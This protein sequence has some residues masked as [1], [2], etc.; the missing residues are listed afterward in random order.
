MRALAEKAREASRKLAGVQPGV[1]NAALLAMA[2]QLTGR[3]TEMIEANALDLTA[4]QQRGLSPAMID[5]LRL[6][7]K[8]IQAMAHGIKEVAALPD[9]VG[10]VYDMATRPNGLK[11]G[12]MRVPIGVVAIIYESRP[13]VTADA[14]SLCLKSGNACIL[15]GGSEAVHC[16]RIIAKILD[17]A[18]QS[19]GLPPACIQLVPTQDRQAI[20]DLLHLD[21]LIDLV[22]PRGGKSL[23]ETVV[24]ESRIQV[25]KH[26][27]GICHVY[28]DE[29]ADPQKA[30]N[31]LV[32]SKAQRTGVCNAAESLIVHRSIAASF[33]PQAGD[34][35]RKVG[36][37]MRASQ[38]AAPFL[39]QDLVISANDED[40]RTEFLDLKIAV[41]VV[42]SLD[43]AIDWIN[44]HGSHHTDTIVTENHTSAMRFIHEV[45]SACCHINCSTRFSDGGEYGLGCEIGISTDKLHARGPMGLTEL[46][47]SKWVVFGDGQVRG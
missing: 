24:R 15:R 44:N 2:D 46:T 36:V 37:E 11:I 43:E 13:N 27:D 25:I 12:R 29:A 18:A 42:G 19:A 34:V 4:A 31:I 47:S 23:I 41:G 9:P 14:G 30:L 28:V 39:G 32:N 26:Y 38:E 1:K 3:A 17:E 35:L 45:D 8:R 6:D 22:I 40:F 16:N 20:V 5:R 33:L 7:E 10:A 21:D